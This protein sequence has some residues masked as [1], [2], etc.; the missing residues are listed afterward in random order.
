MEEFL[1]ILQT[2]ENIDQVERS[3]PARASWTQTGLDRA[4]AVLKRRAE[5][6]RAFADE[7][8][9]ML[10]VPDKKF[11]CDGISPKSE[12]ASSSQEEDDEEESEAVL[13]QQPSQPGACG[14]VTEEDLA[15]DADAARMSASAAVMRVM[16]RS[17]VVHVAE[18]YFTIT[19]KL[20]KDEETRCAVWSVC[21]KLA[22]VNG[23]ES[24]RNLAGNGTHYKPL[25]QQTEDLSRFV[26]ANYVW[27]QEHGVEPE[28]VP[29]DV[30][31][32]GGW[33]SRE[34]R[35]C[36]L[37]EARRALLHF[38][39]RADAVVDRL[40]VIFGK[41]HACQNGS[42]DAGEVV[43]ALDTRTRGREDSHKMM[44][45]HLVEDNYAFARRLIPLREDSY[46]EDP[47]AIE[48]RK[49]I[50]VLHWLRTMAWMYTDRLFPGETT[51][52][53]AKLNMLSGFGRDSVR[54]KEEAC[55]LVAAMELLIRQPSADV[56]TDVGLVG[57]R[58]MVAASFMKEMSRR[59]EG[60][61]PSYFLPVEPKSLKLPPASLPAPAFIPGKLICPPHRGEAPAPLAPPN[62]FRLRKTRGV[63][64]LGPL[65]PEEHGTTVD[66]S[67]P[68]QWRYVPMSIKVADP[69]AFVGAISADIKRC[70]AA[71]SV[72]KTSADIQ[73]LDMAE[74]V[75]SS[76]VGLNRVMPRS[77]DHVVPP[78]QRI[79]G[80][81]FGRLPV[82]A[83]LETHTRELWLCCNPEPS[84]L[85]SGPL[86][87]NSRG[88]RP[89]EVGN[90]GVKGKDVT[91]FQEH[92]ALSFVMWLHYFI[93]TVRGFLTV[94]LTVPHEE[95]IS[96][97]VLL[98]DDLNMSTLNTQ[99]AY[100]PGGA[101]ALDR[102]LRS[103][104]AS[105]TSPGGGKGTGA[106]CVAQLRVAAPE[107]VYV[108]VDFDV[109]A[110]SLD[111]A[112]AAL[113]ALTGTEAS[114]AFVGSTRVALVLPVPACNE[115]TRLL[116]RWASVSVDTHATLF[117]WC[118][119]R[120]DAGDLLR[121][122]VSMH[123]VACEVCSM[124][125][126]WTPAANRID[127][128]GM[129]AF[130]RFMVENMTLSAL[131]TVRPDGL[132][133]CFR[134]GGTGGGGGGIL[135]M[136]DGTAAV[137]VRRALFETDLLRTGCE[138][139]ASRRCQELD[140]SCPEVGPLCRGHSAPSRAWSD[141][142][143]KNN[144]HRKINSIG[145]T[146]FVMDSETVMKP[147]MQNGMTSLKIDE[148]AY[149]QHQLEHSQGFILAAVPGLYA[150]KPVICG[151]NLFAYFPEFDAS[152][153][154][155]RK[156]PGEPKG[157]LATSVGVAVQRYK[158][159]V[160]RF[161]GCLIG[162]YGDSSM[163]SDGRKFWRAYELRM[164]TGTWVLSTVDYRFSTE[165]EPCVKT[166][167][168][169]GASFSHLVNNYPENPS[170][171]RCPFYYNWHPMTAFSDV[172]VETSST[173]SRTK[174][175]V[176]ASTLTTVLLASG[177][178]GR[179]FDRPPPP[180]RAPM[181]S[182]ILAS[183]ESAASLGEGYRLAVAPCEPRKRSHFSAFGWQIVR[184]AAAGDDVCPRDAVPVLDAMRRLHNEKNPEAAA[185]M[186]HFVARHCA[187]SEEHA[188]AMEA[189]PGGVSAYRDWRDAQCATMAR[190]ALSM[191]VSHIDAALSDPQPG[192]L[193]L[194]R[195]SC[196]SAR[197]MC[198]SMIDCASACVS[199][200]ATPARAHACLM[201]GARAA[202]AAAAMCSLTPPVK[203]QHVMDVVDAVLE[204]EGTEP[205]WLRPEDARLDAFM[206]LH[207]AIA[208]AR[209]NDPLDVHPAPNVMT[210]DR[211]GG[212]T[213][214]L[215]AVR[216][217]PAVCGNGKRV[218]NATRDQR[219]A[220]RRMFE[221]LCRG[222][223]DGGDFMF[224]TMPGLCVASD[225]VPR[226]QAEAVASAAGKK[227][228]RVQAA[229]AAAAH[230][231]NVVPPYVRSFRS[232]T[233]FFVGVAPPSGTMAR[234]QFSSGEKSEN[235][236]IH[237]VRRVA[238]I[239][240]IEVSAA[241][242]PEGGPS[243]EGVTS[244]KL[245]VGSGTKKTFRCDDMPRCDED[246]NVCVSFCSSDGVAA[247][248][249][250][251]VFDGHLDSMYLFLKPQHW[252]CT[253]RRM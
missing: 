149:K 170:N 243:I 102:P 41:L 218:R 201:A 191:L 90:C 232:V 118:P 123:A 141:Q 92:K 107:V 222:A 119:A 242:W 109:P 231:L 79:V 86:N 40:T 181:T 57:A 112:V 146:T 121:S 151:K 247:F 7:V 140:V 179:P 180:Q 113:D 241:F 126:G 30:A 78:D 153:E 237:T 23:I 240:G 147:M 236:H 125:T 64:G 220:V 210:V 145:G 20:D 3:I 21:D 28:D 42:M 134:R 103:Q 171:P 71:R 192:A 47:C 130:A 52:D 161:V 63:H 96:I 31:T 106:S 212:V 69:V 248:A 217:H 10:P 184:V 94:P 114:A 197:S 50:A 216:S 24:A 34:D 249:K 189:P 67:G 148:G 108:R 38:V 174:Q 48:H 65:R 199:R 12:D 182:P 175:L 162:G 62:V 85:A 167:K 168:T 87:Q 36:K 76:V 111:A 173:R 245:I 244:A 22:K 66:D 93:T 77:Y 239:E 159:K 105:A 233:P 166:R 68:G 200:W 131:T 127:L 188:V 1:E 238:T 122:I 186:R 223:M 39:T 156:V 234:L 133:L 172:P 144:L 14:V 253:K 53:H 251:V 51:A 158:N 252:L 120:T 193:D 9:S 142:V 235:V 56:W 246:G 58:Q 190:K 250:I 198:V 211:P 75:A 204:R 74:F 205:L 230:T 208:A 157:T 73:P 46:E 84:V 160:R 219:F 83:T 45:S 15:A 207:D 2:A 195:G 25:M 183:V 43:R 213:V 116:S 209:F 95:P 155:P 224:E 154:P 55:K 13:P 178:G 221:L 89:R 132:A 163:T 19:T 81:P 60:G 37:R 35:L 176:Q 128:A 8:L 225:F 100:A 124:P 177:L 16:E 229:T 143:T 228:K 98:Y 26:C 203:K 59:R 110:S 137:A 82:G 54:R 101:I 196:S 70:R 150:G 165:D 4:V 194:A 202:V 61:I 33:K 80:T 227:R 27:M 5:S 99:P 169:L 104:P 117:D 32:C 49:V 44:T 115:P 206:L 136:F 11:S 139:D 72:S 88:G 18:R 152:K 129:G 138:M 185:M 226:K 164:V 6:D 215:V 214:P 91:A 187:E 29:L 135:E 97:F 17:H